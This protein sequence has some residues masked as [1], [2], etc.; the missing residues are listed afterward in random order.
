MA[1]EKWDGDRAV[2]KITKRIVENGDHHRGG[3]RVSSDKAFER[4]KQIVQE[5]DKKRQSERK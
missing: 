3:E 2:D 4:A 5:A 1:K